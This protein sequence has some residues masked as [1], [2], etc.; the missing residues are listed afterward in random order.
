MILLFFREK[1]ERIEEVENIEKIEKDD[2]IEKDEKD[3][4]IKKQRIIPLFWG[5]VCVMP[6][7]ALRAPSR[8]WL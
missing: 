3:E 8:G 7:S 5:W 2:E 1:Y 6:S 4:K